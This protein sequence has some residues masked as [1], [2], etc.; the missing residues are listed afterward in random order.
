MTCGFCLH[1]LPCWASA[2]DFR[3]GGE[4][5]S[6]C[7]PK[8]VIQGYT[9]EDVRTVIICGPSLKFVAIKN[10]LERVSVKH[11]CTGCT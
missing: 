1:A 4:A 3:E 9:W 10:K 7:V 8:S 2:S 6:V 11:R 5:G